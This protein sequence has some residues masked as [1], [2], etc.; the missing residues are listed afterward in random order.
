MSQTSTT[1]F[2][3]RHGQTHWNVERRLQGHLNSPLT[4]TGKR[5]ALAAGEALKE[6]PITAAF[7]SP[8]G[9]AMETAK[10][11]IGSR[12]IPLAPVEGL[13]EIGLGPLEGLPIEE[14]EKRHPKACRDFWQ[15]PHHFSLSGA[16][17]FSQVQGRVVNAITALLNT[18]PG[19]TLLVVSHAIAIKTALAFYLKKE[20][21]DLDDIRLPENGR[22]LTLTADDRGLTLLNPESCLIAHGV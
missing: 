19:E 4:E 16:E 13:R 6:R 5:Q 9:R 18:H 8:S 1:L 7:T 14:A 20:L 10:G 12:N 21:S 22:I 2:L 17:R 11:I 15:A 3:V